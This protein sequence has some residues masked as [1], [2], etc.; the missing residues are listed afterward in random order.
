MTDNRSKLDPI[1]I[2]FDVD[3]MVATLL[4]VCYELLQ[5][6]PTARLSVP[7]VDHYGWLIDELASR[8]ADVDRQ[9]RTDGTDR[10][11]EG[12]AAELLA[13]ETNR[14][15][16]VSQRIADTIYKQ[17]GSPSRRVRP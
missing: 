8:A 16:V 5:G 3:P 10:R 14:A 2:H 13:W 11:L 12:A 7:A 17:Y 6:H 1:R 4:M 9:L 15:R